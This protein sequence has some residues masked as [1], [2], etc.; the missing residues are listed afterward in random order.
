[1]TQVTSLNAGV[2]GVLR[3]IL[4]N[5]KEGVGV[6]LTRNRHPVGPYSKTMPRLL[7]QSSRG[8]V[9]RNMRAGVGV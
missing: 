9:E 8:G 5:L 6:S 1:M 3:D 4:R 2:E 7:W